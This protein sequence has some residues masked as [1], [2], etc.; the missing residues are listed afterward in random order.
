MADALRVV[1]PSSSDAFRKTFPNLFTHTLEW[2][3][4]GGEGADASSEYAL[5]KAIANVIIIVSVCA[6]VRAPQNRT[7]D[8]GNRDLLYVF[9]KLCMGV[10]RSPQVLRD[11][12]RNNNQLQHVYSELVDGHGAPGAELIR[13]PEHKEIIIRYLSEHGAYL[14]GAN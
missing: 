9:S 12:L 6:V 7:L 4:G 5:S 1:P 3:S 13:R 8:L 2:V 10:G 11:A 14:Q